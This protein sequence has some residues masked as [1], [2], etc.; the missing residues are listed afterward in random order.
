MKIKLLVYFL[1]IFL[2][3]LTTSFG[4][5]INEYNMSEF[6][7]LHQGNRWEYAV[8]YAV[9]EGKSNYS[10]A[11]VINGKTL[12]NG[13]ETVTMQVLN[14]S[15]DF[16]AMTSE[17]LKT[18]KD[19]NAEGGYRIEH[20]PVLEFPAK[21]KQGQSFKHVHTWE[22][23]YKDG[24][25]EDTGTT[26]ISGKLQTIEN[27]TVPAG[28]FNNCLKLSYVGSYKESDGDYGNYSE[29]LWLAKG[30]GIVRKVRSEDTKRFTGKRETYTK[31]WQLKKAVIDKVDIGI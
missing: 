21:M 27:I 18:Y 2:S 15:C 6:F 17:G 19:T 3:F 10:E 24:V 26:K 16:I 12:V 1:A 28:T 11:V 7:P 30:V 23:H 25:L 9:K 29:T 8:E 20:T 22:C 5:V 14:G 13:I 31:E 4:A